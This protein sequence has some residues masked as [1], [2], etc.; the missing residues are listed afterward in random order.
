[1][2]EKSQT[3][4]L[5]G[6][7]PYGY[8]VDPEFG[9]VYDS[10]PSGADDLTR[11]R[12]I[13]TREAVALNSL[14]V[15]FIGQMA[16][17]R[18]QQICAFADE[19]GMAPTQVV[20]ERWVEQ[21]QYLSRPASVVAATHAMPASVIRT[22]SLLV[23]AVLVGCLVVYWL[24]L[25]QPPAMRGVL[26]AEIT[27][28]RV[29]EEAR[30]LQVHVRTGSEVFSGEKL[31]TLEKSEHLVLIRDQQQRVRRL[32]EQL[33]QAEA[34]ATLEL[35][36]R[37]RDIERELSEVKA[38]A[39][40][41]RDVKRQTVEPLRTVSSTSEEDEDEDNVTESAAPAATG[42]AVSASRTLEIAAIT[43]QR[44]NSLIF[45]SGPTG[46]GTIDLKPA[47]RQR[48]P[49][50]KAEPVRPAPAAPKEQETVRPESTAESR[51]LQL[52]T[53]TVELRLRQLEEARRNLP[54]Q[55]RQAAGIEALRL[56]H[57]EAAQQLADMNA[58]SREVAV[59]CPAYGTVAEIR[60][61]EG[62]AVPAGEVIVK[63]LHTDRR[64][65]LVRVPGRRVNELQAGATLDLMFPG[66]ER[67]EGT[68][69][70]V[71][72]LAEAGQSDGDSMTV[73][74]VEPAG[75]LWPS[76]PVGTQIDVIVPR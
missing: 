29:P 3:T 9:T 54:A 30:L 47:I 8:H 60:F 17:W 59:V 5:R 44:P 69:A 40:L 27:S 43:A 18:Q 13:R 1:M 67:F 6:R 23:C 19:L 22:C 52:E 39:E 7:L 74:R 46:A 42:Q 41:I 53:R 34:Q 63:V 50:I 70:Q 16:L 61:R 28:L 4:P 2:A 48:L 72:M 49:E 15:Y 36:W 26:S 24:A 45:V 65:V 75:R 21:A 68:V 62:D 35:E 51:L 32:E 20:D 12:G 37:A 76:I 33:E 38:R 66:G 73:V 58:L 31:L 56:R 57:G 55:V 14:G 10:V 64:F 25:R 11:I 71:P